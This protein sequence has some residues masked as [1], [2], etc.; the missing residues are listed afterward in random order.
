VPVGVV[1]LLQDHY[2][3]R[4]RV[5]QASFVGGDGDLIIQALGCRSFTLQTTG[6]FG[7]GNLTIARCNDGIT[8]ANL[9]PGITHNGPS[10]SALP[11]ASIGWLF[12][13]IRILTG[14]SLQNVQLFVCIDE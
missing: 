3:R 5:I 12:Y 8:F 2:I 10:Y 11:F 14:S 13:R 6:V 4:V 9:A 1:T 7:G